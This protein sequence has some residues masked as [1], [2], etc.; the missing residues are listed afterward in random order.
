M[1]SVDQIPP[2]N[3]ILYL[4]D[5][6]FHVSEIALTLEMDEFLL[7]KHLDKKHLEIEQTIHSEQEKLQKIA[8]AKEEMQRNKEHT[9]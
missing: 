5:S 8:V 3:K 9:L 2:L 4:R 6:G 1:Y 7:L